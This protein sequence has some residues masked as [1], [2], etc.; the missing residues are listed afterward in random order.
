LI[1]SVNKA[2]FAALAA[3]ISVAL[4]AGPDLLEGWGMLRLRE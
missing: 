4:L 2:R 3:L 1:Q